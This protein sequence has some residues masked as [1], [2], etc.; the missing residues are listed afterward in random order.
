MIFSVA[1]IGFESIMQV[2]FDAALR[3]EA[4]FETQFHAEEAEAA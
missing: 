4:N 2:A 1:V 3:L